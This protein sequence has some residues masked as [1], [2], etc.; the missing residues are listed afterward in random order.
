MK[1]FINT[2]NIV[3]PRKPSRPRFKFRENRPCVQDQ[4]KRNEL[5]EDKAK[6]ANLEWRIVGATIM[7]RYPVITSDA[8]DWEADFREVQEEISIK[9]KEVHFY[10]LS[11][12][13]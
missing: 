6:Q 3:I 12:D 5:L 10:M 9:R 11:L 8:P 13:E 4:R 1:R 7:H 2:T